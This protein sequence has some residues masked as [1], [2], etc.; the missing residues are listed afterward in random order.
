MLEPDDTLYVHGTTELLVLLNKPNLNPFIFFDSGKDDYIATRMYGGSFA[1]VIEEIESRT[2]KIA[3]VSRLQRVA[4]RADLKEWSEQHYQ[5][6]ELP[7]Y[8]EI[9]S[10]RR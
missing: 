6:L 7:G 3:A 2:P 5:S 4:H 9:G 8:E 1:A 10:R